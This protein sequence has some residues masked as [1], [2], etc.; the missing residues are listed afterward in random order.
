MA[1]EGDEY[2]ERMLRAAPYH[3]SVE[4]LRDAADVRGWRQIEAARARAAELAEHPRHRR[5]TFDDGADAAA[6]GAGQGGRRGAH[7]TLIVFFATARL[8]PLQ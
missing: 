5:G 3:G 7:L 8:P 6:A 1:G 4:K 2:W